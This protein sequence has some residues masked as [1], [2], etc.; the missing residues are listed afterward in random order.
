MKVN[1]GDQIANYL[2]LIEVEKRKKNRYFLCKCLSCG[3][4]KEVAK[5]TLIS[6]QGNSRCRNC[7]K[8]E[9]HPLYPT[10]KSMKSRCHNKN[11]PAF[12]LYGGAGRY[13]CDRWKDSFWD[14]CL[15]VGPRPEGTTLDRVDN[16]KGYEPGNV[17]WATAFEQTRN[18]DNNIWVEVNGLQYVEADLA[19]EFNIPRTTIQA[20]RRRGLTN[21]ELIVRDARGV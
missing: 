4:V 10:W 2:V 20:R 1:P 21:E 19:R 17:R 6:K 18:T 3:W 16:S 7:E 8:S 5:S 9:D 12:Y 13:V 15:D 11:N 14:F